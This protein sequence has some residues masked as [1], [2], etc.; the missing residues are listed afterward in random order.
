[1]GFPMDV[2][3]RMLRYVVA[4]ADHGT[5]TAAARQL[6]IS[7]PSVSSAIASLEAAVGVQI[8]VRHYARGVMLTPAGERLIKEARLLLKHAADFT[9]SSQELGTALKGEIAIACFETLAA[10]FMPAL[11][12]KFARIHPSITVNLLE[13]DQEEILERLLSGRAELALGYGLALSAVVEAEILAEMP[14]YVVIASDHRLAKR[15]IIS[16]SELESESFLL[17]DFPHSREYFFEL[18]AIA[19]IKP[20]ISFQS[21][22]YELLRGLVAHNHGYTIQNAIPATEMTYDGSTVSLLPISDKVPPIMINL[23]RLRQHR[24][25]PSVEAFAMF[26][27]REFGP[28]GLFAKSIVPAPNSYTR[29]SKPR[30]RMARK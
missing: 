9:Q 3:L 8:F 12:A 7:Q 4:A 23:L 19:R 16:L 25:R 30:R 11:L 15:K 22:S 18:F 2:S 13:G 1:M 24:P 10:R 14:P 28:S 21:R 17:L 6:N 29:K 26:L 27:Q 20:K 5:L